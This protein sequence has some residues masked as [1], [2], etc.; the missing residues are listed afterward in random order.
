MAASFTDQMRA[1]SAAIDKAL[2]DTVRVVAIECFGGV[3][4]GT[5]VGNPSLWQSPAPPGYTGG[6]ARANWQLTN[7]APATGEVN[8]ADSGTATRSAVI[9]EIPRLQFTGKYTL[10]NNVPYIEKLEDGTGST[11]APQGMVKLN[12]ARV[13]PMIPRIYQAALRRNGAR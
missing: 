1:E 13:E 12:V 10:A 4:M 5:P 6:T 7:A 11:Q 8:A 2:K 9:S 3:I